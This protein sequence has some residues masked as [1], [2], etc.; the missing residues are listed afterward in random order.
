M[1][2]DEI[3]VTTEYDEYFD[4]KDIALAIRN[5]TLDCELGCSLLDEEIINDCH[6][7]SLK[8]I[9]D[10]IDEVAEAY[11]KETTTIVSTFS[12]DQRE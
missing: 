5:S 11:I 7:C 12:V 4:K 3:K 9:C 2:K 6:A 10:S 1:V 8:S